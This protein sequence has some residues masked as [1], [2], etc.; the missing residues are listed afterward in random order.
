MHCKTLYPMLSEDDFFI[1]VDIP[2][3]DIHAMSV[4]S[5]MR[6]QVFWI[7]TRLDPRVERRKVGPFQTEEKGDG[8]AVQVSR[9]SRLRSIDISMRVDPDE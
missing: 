1:L 9:F 8:T 3:T 6:S 2:Q 7:Q 5:R 4:R